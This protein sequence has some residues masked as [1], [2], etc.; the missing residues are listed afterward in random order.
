MVSLD[1]VK[2]LLDDPSLTDEQI[3]QIRDACRALATLMLDNFLDQ[4]SEEP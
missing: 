4:R 3:L 2:Q 1:T